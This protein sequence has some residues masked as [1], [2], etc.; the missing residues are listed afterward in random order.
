M[1]LYTRSWGTGPRVAVLLHGM[2]GDSCGWWQIGPALAE[3][4]YRAVAVG[5]PGH[6]RS[7]RSEAATVE[8]FVASLLDAV[9]AEPALAI[10]HSMGGSIL[11]AAV[12]RLKPRQAV[13]IDT[14]FGATPADRTDTV[15]LTAGYAA[16]KQQRTMEVLRR[17]RPWWSETDMRV[18]VE[19][20]RCFDP[21]TAAAL[22]ASAAGRDFTPSAAIPSLMIRAEPSNYV[23]P[24]DA[25]GLQALGF[26]VRSIPGAGHTVWYGYFEQFMTALDGWIRPPARRPDPPDRDPDSDH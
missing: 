15:A 23:S 26:E 3:R 6:G 10:G 16:S 1:Q 20:A 12:D 21:P 17:E 14:P 7:P 24:A 8:W 2:M 22:S 18:E 4:G 5:L 9:P 11:A 25:A 13:Y 19:A